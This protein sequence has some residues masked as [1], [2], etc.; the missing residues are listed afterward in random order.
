[1]IIV[2]DG[3]ERDQLAQRIETLNIQ[4]QVTLLGM[5]D[6]VPALLKQKALLLVMTSEHEG[7]SNALIEAMTAGVPVLSTPVG[8]APRLIHNGVN[9]YLIPQDDAKAVAEQIAALAVD[10]G[11]LRRLGE[12]GRAQ[13]L[14][15]FSYEHLGERV[16]RLYHDIAVQAQHQRTLRALQLYRS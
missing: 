15:H 11:A 3:P 1:M 2:G 5:R 16:L 13:I 8:D 12:A 9:G 6:D 10:E 7:F 14:E 4:Q